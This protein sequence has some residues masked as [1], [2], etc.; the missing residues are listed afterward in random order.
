[1]AKHRIL[2]AV[3]MLVLGVVLT[4][5][6]VHAVDLQPNG[7]S[8]K[9]VTWELEL[10]GGVKAKLTAASGELVRLTREDGSEL[11]FIPEVVAGGPTRFRVFEVR[12]VGKKE[13]LR[14]VEMI[15]VR[16]G[17][18][19]YSQKISGLTMRLAQGATRSS[20]G[21]VPAKAELPS[22]DML[23]RWDL[24]LPTGRVVALVSREGEMT[25]MKLQDGQFFGFVPAI[26]E[27]GYVAFKVFSLSQV[28]GLGEVLHP[29][30]TFVV[31]P[32]ADYFPRTLSS[33]L[34]KLAGVRK[35]SPADREE[36]NKLIKDTPDDITGRG[37]CVTCEGTKVCGCAVSMDC[38]DC[39]SAPCC[40]E[41]F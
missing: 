17:E 11:A 15:E 5:G 32:G 9:L 14:P 23:V 40:F 27:D 1:M 31:Q 37:C 29:M 2:F 35:I 4:A 26:R 20:R 18:E 36:L 21:E 7:E 6:F 24:T 38:G 30:E 3:V 39:C 41:A 34:V 13:S 12:L 28:K 16:S 8:P 22:S 33:S 25:R 10:S 19:A